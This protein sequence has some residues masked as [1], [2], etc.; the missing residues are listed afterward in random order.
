MTVSLPVKTLSAL[1]VSCAFLAACGGGGS[2]GS[3]PTATAN[4]LR[5]PGSS[6]KPSTPAS[7]PSA[8]SSTT[9]TSGVISITQAPYNADPTGNTDSTN[10]IQNA[11]TA[12]AANG[13][14]VSIP[15]GTFVYSNTLNANGIAVT[16]AGKASI[17]KATNVANEAFHLTGT[18]GSLSNFAM[19]S[20]A[21]T[22][23][24]GAWE[25][26]MVW[27]DGATNFNVQGITITGSASA[28][29]FNNGGQGGTIQNNTVQNTLADS[30]T[31]TN[32]AN[33]TVI[34]GNLVTGSGDDGIS[35]VS[36]SNAPIVQ[37]ITVKNNTVKGQVWG[38]GLSVV[39][40]N[41]VTYTGNVVDNTDS[42]ADLY[43]SAES[44]YNTLGVS[45]VTVSGNTFLHGGASQGTVTVYN[46][47]GSTYNISGVNMSGNQIV[48]PGFVGFQ[49]V[50]NG[51]ETGT[52]QNSTLYSALGSPALQ[53][54]GN[55]KSNF[56]VTGTTMA[57]VSAYST[58][59][60]AGGAGATN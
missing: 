55:S 31:N 33:G 43:I 46:S 52:V 29:I 42:Y 21:T 35:I 57:A 28:G 45:N 26:A 40:G 27:I 18:G 8:A 60:A 56:P 30:I 7:S 51:I 12:A 5:R 37:N 23:S 3:D 24:N 20:P 25:T 6:T 13:S 19:T 47:Q 2:D 17:L 53:N 9:P 50:G 48:N 44:E 16:G 22:R 38:R 14:S 49:F 54:N 59:A 32:G 41:N 36:Y 10:A 4:R 15:A 34:S 39:G 58:P 1:L 11:L